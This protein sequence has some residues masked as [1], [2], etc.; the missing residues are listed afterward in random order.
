[1][2]HS[3]PCPA[4]P[5]PSLSACRLAHVTVLVR[6]DMCYWCAFRAPWCLSKLLVRV[7]VC[8]AGASVIV[9]QIL[10]FV[11]RSAT[12][13]N[14]AYDGATKQCLANLATADV[15]LD[16][17]VCFR[18]DVRAS[19]WNG[20]HSCVHIQFHVCASFCICGEEHCTMGSLLPSTCVLAGRRARM[21][22]TTC[23]KRP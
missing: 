17:C 6:A 9:N 2:L 23:T 19:M 3:M 22:S 15:C 12:P 7:S 5:N 18:A 16:T 13:C 11:A 21:H 8:D 10:G 20:I 14:G 4:R 1:M